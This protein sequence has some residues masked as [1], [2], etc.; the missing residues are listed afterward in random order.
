[1]EKYWPGPLTIIKKKK[2]NKNP[3]SIF[4]KNIDEF[5]KYVLNYEISTELVNGMEKYWPGPLTIIFK[6]KNNVFE[7]L[8][9]GTNT[10]GIRIPNDKFLLDILNNIN[11]P[12][13]QTSCNISGEE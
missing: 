13:A 3:F 10:I 2:N 7:H 12:L 4:I 1:M 8:T 11:V 5:K 6:K 9:E